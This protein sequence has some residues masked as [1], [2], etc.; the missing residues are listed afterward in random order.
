MIRVCIPWFLALLLVAHGSCSDVFVDYSHSVM[1]TGTVLSDYKMGGVKSSEASGSL[2]GTGDLIN[3]QV[4]ST[5]GTSLFTVEDKFLLAQRTGGN[6][7]DE[8]NYPPWP[9]VQPTFRLAGPKWA[10]GIDIKAYP[11]PEP[12]EPSGVLINALSFA[13]LGKGGEFEINGVTQ[14]ASASTSVSNTSSMEVGGIV[15]IGPSFDYTSK[16]LNSNNVTVQSAVG[17]PKFFLFEEYS[18]ILGNSSGKKA[19]QVA[20]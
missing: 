16:W 5:N 3:K 8:V 4:F 15:T 11:L 10:R 17:S 20:P 19:L 2:R 1:G 6:V 7:K 13:S 14:L 18:R 12:A 9:K